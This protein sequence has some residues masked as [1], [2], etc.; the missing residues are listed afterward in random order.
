VINGILRAGRRPVLLATVPAE[1]APYGAQARQVVNLN[2][3]QD[4]HV[5]NRPPTS[6]WPVR[7]ALWMSQPG[8]A[9]FGS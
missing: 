3:E 9:P 8:G 7:Y 5:L 4:A 2:S 1:L 6:A